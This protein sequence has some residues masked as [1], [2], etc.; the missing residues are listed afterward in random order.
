[1]QRALC[2]HTASAGLA[3]PGQSSLE[4]DARKQFFTQG[5]QAAQAPHLHGATP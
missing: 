3:M 1:M 5:E 4:D 2:M